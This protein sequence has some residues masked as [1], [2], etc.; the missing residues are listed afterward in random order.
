MEVG[1]IS[2]TN[3][4]AGAAQSVVFESESIESGQAM[5]QGV[6][7]AVRSGGDGMFAEEVMDIPGSSHDKLTV[8]SQMYEVL[9]EE[10]DESVNVSP[11]AEDSVNEITT[12]VDSEKEISETSNNASE[13]QIEEEE[14]I[15][16]KVMFLQSEAIKLLANTLEGN[17]KTRESEEL[18]KKVRELLNQ[19]DKKEI[20]KS[21][22]EYLAGAV[23]G[24]ALI[25]VKIAEKGFGFVE[26]EVRSN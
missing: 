24:V 11:E 4:S 14:P 6:D 18:L 7:S 20:E 8:L 12:E 19:L 17:Y 23:L 25:V 13:E 9:E 1:E 3:A 10:M 22:K 15:E 2:T 5:Q 26:E 16:Q 21:K